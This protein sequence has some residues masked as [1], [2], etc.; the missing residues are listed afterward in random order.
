MSKH[1]PMTVK[2]VR[3]LIAS[4]RHRYQTCRMVIRDWSDYRLITEAAGHDWDGDEEA[5]EQVWRLWVEVDRAY[6]YLAVGAE[7]PE[8]FRVENERSGELIGLAVRDGGRCWNWWLG[9]HTAGLADDCTDGFG[10]LFLHFLDPSQTIG[11]DLE[12]IG[13]VEW[14]GRRA[15]GVRDHEGGGFF[16]GDADEYDF[17][18]DLERGVLLRMEAF[19]DGRTLAIE[20]TID[21]GFDE[22]L[23]DG[24]F[25]GEECR[26]A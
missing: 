12:V 11:E 6:A 3:A 16:L 8:R 25:D 23:D 2:E 15:I 24:L 10:E 9:E 13:E 26:A 20:E 5:G 21:V 19:R 7:L 22:E 14:T 18:F 1:R 4:A 17:L